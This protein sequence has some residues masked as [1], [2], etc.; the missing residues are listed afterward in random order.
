MKKFKVLLLP[1]V[2]ALSSCGGYSLDYIVEGDKYLSS[3]F[4]KNFYEH[5]DSELANAYHVGSPISVQDNKIT[6]F[7]NVGL[8][9]PHYATVDPSSLNQK[10]YSETHKLSN[11]DQM[12]MY[13]V[14]SKLFDGRYV[15][16]GKHQ[17]QL[18]MQV[19][20]TGFSVRF[21]KESDA[22]SYFAMNFKVTTNNQIKCYKYNPDPEAE[23]VLAENDTDLFHNSNIDIRV[24]IYVKEFSD[25][26]AYDF[27]SNLVFNNNSTNDGSI[28]YF[29][30]FDLSNIKNQ[31]NQ[32][33]S[34]MVGFS[35]TYTAHDELIDY[36]KNKTIDDKPVGTIDYALFIYEVYLPYTYWH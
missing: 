29:Y 19:R 2:A 10:N 13:G 17:Q 27:T 11:S 31:Y 7:K 33:L 3:D 21:S 6:N 18:R 20:E 4:K 12:F 26:V 1:L 25:I 14:Q 5:W 23:P 16:D 24:T 32:P 30:A 34:R 8:I 36:N 35:I 28:Y 22:L 15:C 9:D